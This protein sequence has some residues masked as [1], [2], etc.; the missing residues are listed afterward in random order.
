[1]NASDDLELR[2][3]DWMMATASSG[4]PEDLVDRTVAGL[5][6]V[7]QR[8]GPLVRTGLDRRWIAAP[9]LSPAARFALVG[10]LLLAAAVAAVVVGSRLLQ[11]PR[12][13]FAS[14]SG[15]FVSIAPIPDRMDV[16]SMDL[17]G[18][19]RVLL[20]G[21]QWDQIGAT[22]ENWTGWVLKIWDPTASTFATYPRA[23]RPPQPPD[24]VPSSKPVDRAVPLEDGRVLVI[25]GWEGPLGQ[26]TSA[27]LFDPGSGTFSATGSLTTPRLSMASV[28]LA[29]GRVL[30]SGGEPPEDDP[31]PPNTADGE[32]A[33]AS[34]DLFDPA[35]NGFMPVGTMTAPRLGHSMTLLADGRVLVVGG[36]DGSET[37]SHTI[38]SAELFDP[39]SRTF[40]PTGSMAEER[41]NFAV[42]P[43]RLADGRVLVIGGGT[44]DGTATF[45]LAAQLKRSGTISTEIY[46]PVTGEF[47]GGPTIPR[48]VS[49]ATLLDDEIVLLTGTWWESHQKAQMVPSFE[50]DERHYAWAGLLDPAS[51][52]IVEIP[53]VPGATALESSPTPRALR[54]SDGR[55]LVVEGWDANDDDA[56]EGVVGLFQPASP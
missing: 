20:T 34:S 53:P 32:P 35:A 31:L 52:S 43:V 36:S 7:R 8:P 49:T 50:R 48:P 55:I 28:R 27:E 15:V 13:P 11:T 22:G 42:A 16:V 5:D 41:S 23:I 14:E 30:V 44:D 38:R 4:E 54:L 17:L 3:R 19:G 39:T 2:L 18:D 33:L 21:P 12:P 10:L 24:A 6:R 9:T 26:T 51:G 37:T 29:D 47:S 46:D 56:P 45:D 1:M 25:D 40:S